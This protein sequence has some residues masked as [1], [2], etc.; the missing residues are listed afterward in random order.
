MRKG[1]DKNGGGEGERQ[2]RQPENTKGPREREDG[3]GMQEKQRSPGQDR[4]IPAFRM[5][6]IP[7]GLGISAPTWPPPEHSEVADHQTS[8]CVPSDTP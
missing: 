7:W 5:L 4:V 6:G 1:R 2:R 3:D 8:G